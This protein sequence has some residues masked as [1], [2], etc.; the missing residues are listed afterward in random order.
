MYEPGLFAALKSNKQLV[1]GTRSGGD[2]DGN[3][4]DQFGIFLRDVP[5]DRHEL[6]KTALQRL[7]PRLEDMGYTDEWLSEWKAERRVCVEAYFDTYFRLSLSDDVLSANQIKE[8][9]DK[10]DDRHF[11]QT[12]F[13]EASKIERRSGQSMIPVYLDALNTNAKRI[14]KSKVE[15]LLGALFEIHD[16]IDEE[17]DADKGF[18]AVANTSLRYHWLIRRL[19]RDRF[20]IEERTEVY[21]KAAEC[22]SLGW[23]VDF[24]SSAHGNYRKREGRQ[25]TREEDCLTTEA[26]LKVFANRALNSIRSAAADGSLLAH[27]DLLYILH[28]WVDFAGND[29][30]EARV[31]TDALLDDPKGVVALA[32]AMTGTSWSMGMGGFG[33]L[34]DRVS[35]RSVTAQ[36]RDDSD[37]IDVE[38]FRKAVEESQGSEVLSQ[39]DRQ[40]VRVFLEAW[41]RQRRGEDD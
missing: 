2:P 35:K 34:G 12:A 40:V 39:E 25:P 9:I 20:T 10:A 36:I 6:A 19:T 31:W 1:C 38:V 8:L 13:R 4:Q 28:R 41:D 29:P 30:S 24:V 27:K 17:R 18:M 5:E 16:E 26:A 32:R 15:P 7:F 21:L 14:D 23:L 22:A 33:S 3:N 11:I 37:V